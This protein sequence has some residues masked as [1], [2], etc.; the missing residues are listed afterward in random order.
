VVIA[1]VNTK[2]GVG[3]T[4]A[5]VNLAA[6]LAQPSRRVL[7]VDLDSQASASRW[8]GVER[9]KLKPSLASFLLNGYPV[10]RAIR[11]TSVPNLDLLTGSIELASTDVALSHVPGREQVLKKLLEPLRHTYDLIILDCPPNLSLICVTAFV[12]A[13]AFIVPLTPHFLAVE[14]VAALIGVA[15]RVR[16]RLGS[17]ARLLGMVLTMVSGHAGKDVRKRLRAQYRDKVFYTE[18][19][20][21]LAV[22]EASAAGRTIFQHS[23]RSRASLA[24]TRLASELLERLPARH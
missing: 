8:C 22:E 12:A 4:S 15:E 3:K 7:L 2:G 16:T 9:A 19:P 10:T 6:A 5:A 21:A 17:R 24:F 20:Y 14:G 13:D 23:P 18:I 11:P 1:S